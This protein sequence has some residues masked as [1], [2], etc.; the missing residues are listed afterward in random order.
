MLLREQYFT[1]TQITNLECET[2]LK[3]ICSV[4]ENI[5]IGQQHLPNIAP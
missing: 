4:S 1:H 5:F 3:K 2:Q